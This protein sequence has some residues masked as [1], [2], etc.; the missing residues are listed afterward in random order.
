MRPKIPGCDFDSNSRPD[1]FWPRRLI[2]KSRPGPEAKIVAATLISKSRPA[3]HGR[4]VC[5][6]SR[7][8]FSGREI[9][10]RFGGL[11]GLGVHSLRSA[12]GGPPAGRFCIPTR[13]P[14]PSGG[15]PMTGGRRWRGQDLLRLSA[16][17][18]MGPRPA[19]ER[20]VHSRGV[21]FPHTRSARGR[22]GDRPASRLAVPGR[23]GGGPPRARGALPM[24]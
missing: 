3:N 2:S 6:E 21:R 4:N 22:G 10:C 11:P 23:S 9:G 15:G 13:W 5:S 18:V 12:V 20:G 17:A 16:S 14:A 7:P 24:T 8:E 19:R 1:H